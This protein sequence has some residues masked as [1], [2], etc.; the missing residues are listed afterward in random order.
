MAALIVLALAEPVF[1]PRERLPTGGAALALVIDNG[2]ASARRLGPRVATAE[3]L[4]ADAD[5]TGVPVVLAFTAEKP[6]AEIGPFDAAAALDRLQ[7]RQAA[8]GAGRPA[9][10]LCA[11]RRSARSRCPAPSVAVLADGL[12]AQGDEAAFS[13]LLGKNAGERASGP[14]PTGS[15]WSA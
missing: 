9:G 1:N 2:W 12:A 10:D 14:C 11:R 6:N 13:T 15:T 8:P 4:I 7:R 3:R 5:A